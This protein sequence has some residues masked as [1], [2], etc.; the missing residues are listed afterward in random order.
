MIE[1]TTTDIPSTT[2]PACPRCGRSEGHRTGCDWIDGKLQATSL[3]A[4]DAIAY[5]LLMGRG[6]Y[7]SPEDWADA[8]LKRLAHEGFAV[9]RQE[10][11][12]NGR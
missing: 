8:V 6:M 2:N 1:R 3:A 12:S 7:S 5:C 9:V 10:A 11:S 4:R